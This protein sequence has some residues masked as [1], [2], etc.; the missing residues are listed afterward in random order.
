MTG[1]ECVKEK[2]LSDMRFWV[3][4]KFSVEVAFVR[5]MGTSDKKVVEREF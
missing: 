1:R 5:K 2:F 3:N 4:E